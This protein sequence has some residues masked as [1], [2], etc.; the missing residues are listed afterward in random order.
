M[1][2]FEKAVSTID[3]RTGNSNNENVFEMYEDIIDYSPNSNRLVTATLTGSCGWR[4]KVL[5]LAQKYPDEVQVVHTNKDGSIVAHLPCSYLHIY[6]PRVLSEE[7]KEKYR[8]N[9]KKGNAK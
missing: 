6:R 8:E 2:E 4:T 1:N 9:L 5:K 7:T 3:E